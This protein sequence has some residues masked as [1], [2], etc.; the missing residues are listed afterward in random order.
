MQH[1]DFVCPVVTYCSI[2]AQL[3]TRAGA[4]C[5]Q[6]KS[7]EEARAKATAN[8]NDHY[9]KV[10]NTTDSKKHLTMLVDTLIWQYLPDMVQML[11]QKGFHYKLPD[12]PMLVARD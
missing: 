4:V 11:Q 9:T 6:F 8:L 2:H 5:L 10:V 3:V 7:T 12:V 1:T